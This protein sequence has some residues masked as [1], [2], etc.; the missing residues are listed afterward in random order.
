MMVGGTC[1]IALTLRISLTLPGGPPGIGVGG[2]FTPL[3]M[4]PKTK[5]PRELSAYNIFVREEISRLKASDPAIDHGAAWKKASGAWKTAASNPRG[6]AL[7]PTPASLPAVAPEPAAAAAHSA[8]AT[9]ASSEAAPAD[10]ADAQ[11]APHSALPP[12]PRAGDVQSLPPANAGGD[13]PSVLASANEQ[14]L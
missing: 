11:P 7:P 14:V 8:D 12:P 1:A 13:G 10:G 6:E 2:A 9:A 5:A 4:A 3:A